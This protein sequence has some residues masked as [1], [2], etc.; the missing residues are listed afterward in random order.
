MRKYT[1]TYKENV[2]SHLV[3][4]V[5]IYAESDEDLI[6]KVNTF[7]LGILENTA[8]LFVE[9]SDTKIY[10]AD[11]I[12]GVLSSRITSLGSEDEEIHND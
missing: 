5:D 12:D 1:V 4:R 2:E 6:N 11:N 10:W 7:L 3:K 9:L 8:S